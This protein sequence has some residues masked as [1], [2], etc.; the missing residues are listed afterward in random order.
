MTTYTKLKTGEWGVRGP[1][2]E[3]KAGAV[4]TVTKKSGE[5][6]Q[7]TVS[8]ILWTDGTVALAAI[9]AQQSSGKRRGGT[10]DPD[11]FRGYGRARGGWAKSCP[12]GGNCSS[13]GSGRSCG[14]PDC[15]GF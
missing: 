4:V 9:G 1:V 11:Q 6:K 10:W 13:F 5:A 12:T 15:D 7:E 3:V 8:R 14:S 2:A